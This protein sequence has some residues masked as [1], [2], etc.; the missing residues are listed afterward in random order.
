MAEINQLKQLLEQNQSRIKILSE[1]FQTQIN[2]VKKEV[3]NALETLTRIEREFQLSDSRLAEHQQQISHRQEQLT[4]LRETGTAFE[5]KIAELYTKLSEYQQQIATLKT[6]L[7]E[8]RGRI[9]IVENDLTDRQGIF[10]TKQK[11]I[12]EKQQELTR[13]HAGKDQELTQHKEELSKAKKQIKTVKTMNPV[14][15][16]LL[17]EGL[18]PPEL[19]ILA[20]LIHQKEVP[21]VEIKRFV[22]TPPAIT[23]RVLKE[24]ENKGI[25]EIINSNTIRLS[26]SL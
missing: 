10:D 21:M 24:M 15:D 22:K 9:E 2:S 6:T 16:F 25:L 3:L 26:I 20:L 11:Q 1:S 5:A 23:T 19:D 14:A 4:Q 12:E 17:S 8:T 13:L 7:F 18:E